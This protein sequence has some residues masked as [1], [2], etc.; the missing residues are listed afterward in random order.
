M[1]FSSPAMPRECAVPRTGGRHRRYRR[2]RRA[3]SCQSVAQLDINGDGFL[4]VQ[5]ALVI[6]RAPR[7]SQQ[8]S[9]G[10]YCERQLWNANECCRDASVRC[11]RLQTSLLPPHDRS[12][13]RSAVSDSVDVR[14]QSRRNSV[15]RALAP[16]WLGVGQHAQKAALD[17]AKQSTQHGVARSTLT[18]CWHA[19]WRTTLRVKLSTA[20]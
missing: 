20:K 8:Q 17:L 16:G 12:S 18:I 11:R 9:R 1:V 4:D 13:G 10:R 3:T 7:H 15:V 5:D 2:H 19:R 6:N 14:P